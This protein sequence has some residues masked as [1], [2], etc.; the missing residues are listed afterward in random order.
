[1]IADA[2]PSTT[3]L[4]DATVASVCRDVDAG[5]NVCEVDA[6]GWGPYIAEVGMEYL[7]PSLKEGQMGTR[8]RVNNAWTG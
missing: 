5:V 4:G 6:E 2:G 3:S 1:M 8:K 7:S